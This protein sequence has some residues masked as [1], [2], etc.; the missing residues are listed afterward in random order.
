MILHLLAV[1]IFSPLI[2]GQRSRHC[3]SETY[4]GFDKTWSTVAHA[5]SKQ[6]DGLCYRS[7]SVRQ[8]AP[9][10]ARRTTLS[11][12]LL[13]AATGALLA[14]VQQ[15]KGWSYQLLALQI[16]SYLAVGIICCDVA[17]Q[18][19][20]EWGAGPR[21]AEVKHLAHFHLCRI[22]RSG[23][24]DCTIRSFAAPAANTLL[25]GAENRVS[26]HLFR[27]PTGHCRRST[28][29]IEPWEWPAVL[30]QNK[31]WASRYMHL[32]LLPAIVRSQ[33]PLDAEKDSS[34]AA[35]KDR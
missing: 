25:R 14:Y 9:P 30:E 5:V 10:A 2:S 35:G 24:G 29:G 19:W 21:I 6:A 15:H 12:C 31:T 17:E 27:L 1:R 28:W 13:A 18:M 32:W 16:F 7:N 34:F 33:D 11:S 22:S 3:S 20:L 4:W 23:F 8:L 26:H